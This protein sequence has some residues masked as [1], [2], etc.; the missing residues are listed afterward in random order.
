M[1]SKTPSASQNNGE[2]SRTKLR[3]ASVRRLTQIAQGAS[4]ELEIA[5]PVADA[6]I[7]LLALLDGLLAIGNAAFAQNT[8]EGWHHAHQR[9]L[10]G[11]V[12][13]R[14]SELR[15]AL[16]ATIDPT[17]PQSDERSTVIVWL[18]ALRNLKARISPPDSEENHPGSPDNEADTQYLLSM[19]NGDCDLA[20][21]DIFPRL[22]PM[23][24]KYPEGS[25][26]HSLLVRACEIYGDAA[27]NAARAALGFR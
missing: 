1:K 17:P 4:Y 24:V 19:I 11:D 13:I 2:D 10:D 20:S 7:E 6:H 25:E 23:L 12:L 5:V 8:A 18:M 27:A 22:E 26:M 16:G 9:T 21:A 3:K 15:H 14:V